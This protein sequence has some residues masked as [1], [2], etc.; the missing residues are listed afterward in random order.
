MS[1]PDTETSGLRA[2]V[3]ED[4]EFPG[5]WRVEEMDKD[6]GSEVGVFGGPNARERALRYADREYGEFRRDRTR[7][8]P[9]PRKP[10][11]PVS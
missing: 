3:F 9:K 6:G 5:D 7:A 4:R 1:Q 8:V 2:K 10:P 11:D